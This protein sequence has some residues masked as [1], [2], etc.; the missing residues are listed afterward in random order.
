MQRQQ[1]KMPWALPWLILVLAVPAL[2]GV[3]GGKEL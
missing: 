3:Y 2:A 1:R